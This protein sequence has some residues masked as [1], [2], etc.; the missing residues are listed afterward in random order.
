MENTQISSPSSNCIIYDIE[1][2]K[3]LDICHTINILRGFNTKFFLSEYNITPETM[4]IDD[5][6]YIYAEL[7][8]RIYSNNNNIIYENNN[9][10]IASDKLIY[11]IYNERPK[12]I[13]KPPLPNISLY[14]NID[15]N[16]RLEIWNDIL[17]L[18]GL[19]TYSY[20]PPCSSITPEN[21][22]IEDVTYMYY[23]TISR[24]DRHN[25]K[26]IKKY[27]NIA[28]KLKNFIKNEKKIYQTKFSLTD[29][30]TFIIKKNILYECFYFI[31]YCLIKIKHNIR[32][33]S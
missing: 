21:I 16:K 23:Y 3:K 11:F 26:I 2:N 17:N 32:V 28:N 12:Y 22:T 27:K 18:C 6:H 9:I 13:R 8:S 29:N 10:A 14:Y 15:P 7:N 20:K 25:P 4:T 33:V 1:K 24:I 5:I 31:S 30:N 19:Y